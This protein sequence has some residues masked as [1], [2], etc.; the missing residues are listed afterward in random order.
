MDNDGYGASHIYTSHASAGFQGLDELVE[1]SMVEESE[2]PYRSWSMPPL[3]APRYSRTNTTPSG[4]MRG[5][6]ASDPGTLE[7]A[8]R[9]STSG[10]MSRFFSYDMYLSCTNLTSSSSCKPR[11]TGSVPVSYCNRSKQRTGSPSNPTSVYP[12]QH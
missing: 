2:G 4:Q 10:C 3:L 12:K 8:G 6:S 11:C 9:R 7:H 1:R 5:H